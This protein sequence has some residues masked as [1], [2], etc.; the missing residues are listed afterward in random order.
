[1]KNVHLYLKAVGR[2]AGCV[3]LWIDV[4]TALLSAYG[5]HFVPGGNKVDAPLVAIEDTLERA[6]FAIKSE[7]HTLGTKESIMVA[8][9]IDDHT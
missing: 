3:S 4:P 1:L 6:G 8:E 9:L 2:E 7:C 5:D